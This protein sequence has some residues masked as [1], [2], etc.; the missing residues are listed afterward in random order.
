MGHK[1]SG[2]EAQS[3]IVV[4]TQLGQSKDRQFSKELDLTISKI[5]YEAVAE[6]RQRSQVYHVCS[7]VG[8]NRSV[9]SY[10]HRHKTVKGIV[11]TGVQLQQWR[12]TSIKFKSAGYY[13]KQKPSLPCKI[14]IMT[15]SR[16]E[17]SLRQLGNLKILKHVAAVGRRVFCTKAIFVIVNTG[18]RLRNPPTGNREQPVQNL[19]IEILMTN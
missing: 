16:S 15:F 9:I 5:S 3:C 17:D 7:M 19:V 8:I 11:R 18:F 12:T 10:N 6:Q 13:E 4:T 14:A 1:V 2:C